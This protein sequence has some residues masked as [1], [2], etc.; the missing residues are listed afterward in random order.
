MTEREWREASDMRQSTATFGAVLIAAAL[1]RFWALGAGI[2]YGI[3]V[4]EPQIMNRAYSM[5]RTGDFNPHFFH[6]PGL[7]I[8]VQMLVAVVR[9]LFGSMGGEWHAVRDFAPMD[10]Y[11]WGRAVTAALGTATVALVY[12]CGLRW[13]TRYALLAAGLMAVMP[14]HVRESHF[15]LADVPMTFF[16][17]LTLLFSLRANERARVGAFAWAG[18]AAGLAAGTKYNGALALVLPMLAAWMTPGLRP[19]RL[20]ALLATLAAAAGSFLLVS[21][22]TVLDL[23]AFLDSYGELMASYARPPYGEPV[24]LLYAKHLRIS[25]K[26]PAL[27]FTLA[28]IGLALIRAIKG[29][30]RVRWTLTV[31]FAIMYFWFVSRQT[32]VF[33]RY[34]LPVLPFVCLLASAA[35][36]SG[37]SLLR[38]FSIPR[39]VR[40]TLIVALTVGIILPPAIDAVGFNVARSREGTSKLAYQWIRDNLPAGTSFVYESALLVPPNPPYTSRHIPQ[41]RQHTYE[42]YVKE[43]VQYL[44]ASSQAFGPYLEQPQLYGKEY[45]EYM[46]IFEQSREVARFPASKEHPGAELRIYRVRP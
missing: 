12:F 11:L 29:P 6:Y 10:F 31:T 39:V 14:M 22:Y 35:V 3:G 27:L 8:Y 2:P 33:G 24:W 5:M 1:L 34:L 25:L 41:L 44:I 17:T 36:I 26:W 15:V 40:T 38:R 19:S 32:L 46:R 28:G 30:G 16:V 18:M 43:G 21:P 37:V 4:D 7:Y 42:E 23:P 45:A 9:F 20:L 13:G